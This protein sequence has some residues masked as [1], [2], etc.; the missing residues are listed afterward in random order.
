MAGSVFLFRD[1]PWTAPFATP[2]SLVLHPPNSRSYARLAKRR[3]A[4]ARSKGGG[5][6]QLRKLQQRADEMNYRL[7]KVDPD[8]RLV[9]AA[10]EREYE[11]ALR[12]LEDVKQQIADQERRP[13]PFAAVDMDDIIKALEDPL[14][15]F[16]APTTSDHDRK[17]IVRFLVAAVI[18]EEKTP[19]VVRARIVWVDGVPDTPIE[20]RLPLYPH[21]VIEKMTT[22]GKTPKE[23]KRVLDEMALTTSTGRPWTLETIWLRRRLITKRLG[24]ICESATAV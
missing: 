8:L 6:Q 20:I 23:I 1:R 13:S 12:E 16:L 21:V 11:A 3:R 18:V 22:E 15:V 17:L 2:S 10:L 14:S 24:G 9:A 19:Y 4:K 5:E 7:L